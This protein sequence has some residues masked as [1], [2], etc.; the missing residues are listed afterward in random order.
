VKNDCPTVVID[1]FPESAFRHRERDAVTC[2]DVMLTTTTIV[3]AAAEGRRIYVAAGLDQMRS[4]AAELGDVLIAGSLEG[5]APG[6][7]CLPDGP[8]A[9]AHAGLDPRPLLLASPPGTELIA[10]AAG[11][12]AVFVASFRNLSATAAALACHL[13][14]ALLAAG[15]REEFSCEDQMA[16]AWIAERLLDQGFAPGDP[17]TADIVRRWSGI[18]PSLAGWGN[19][20]ADLRRIGRGDEVDFVIGH[21]DD[22]SCSLVLRG[23]EVSLEPITVGAGAGTGGHAR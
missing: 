9:L 15:C 7:I 10:N 22:V 4:L 13:R 12:A 16:A 6:E 5:A 21:L 3:T 1:S 17:R 11:T 2:I 18:P 23:D 8:C 14:V 20:A 19:S